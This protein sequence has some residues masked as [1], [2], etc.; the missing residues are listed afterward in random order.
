MVLG[1]IH[2]FWVGIHWLWVGSIGS[3]WDP[4]LSCG[5]GWG[6]IGS[7]WD[8]LVLGGDPSALGGIHGCPLALDGDPLALGGPLCLSPL[9]WW[10]SVPW[11]SVGSPPAVPWLRVGSAPHFPPRC[12]GWGRAVPPRLHAGRAGA[13]APCARC[14]APRGPGQWGMGGGGGRPP[15]CPHAHLVPNAVPTLGGSPG[16]TNPPLPRR[17]CSGGSWGSPSS[18]WAPCG[19]AGS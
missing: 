2:W 10:R 1:G 3:G 13:G 11:R 17:A 6:S 15:C 18:A 19:R 5:S 12:P 7:G 14:A 4:W 16:P 8:P 9:L